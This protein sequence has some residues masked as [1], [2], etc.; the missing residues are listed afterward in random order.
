MIDIGGPYPETASGKKYILSIIDVFSRYSK[1]IPLRV[2]DTETIIKALMKDWISVFGFPETIVSDN[3]SNLNGKLFQDFCK[4]FDII[5]ATSSP[6]H[7]EGNSIV[8]RLFRTVKD[9]IFCVHH[10]TGYNWEEA[11]PYVEI[12][13]RTTKTRD[14]KYSPHEIIFGRTLRVPG[15]TNDSIIAQSS[16]QYLDKLRERLESIATKEK[17]EENP[18]PTRKFKVGENV[19]VRKSTKPD[20][21]EGRFF[22][23]AKIIEFVYPKSYVVQYK[24]RVYR[25]HESFLKR[26]D[27]KVNQDTERVTVI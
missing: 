10:S 24:H 5:K 7:P 9:R 23:P 15:L 6:Y 17:P 3:A 26:F 21:Y 27:C 25:R 18:E 12:G 19:M 16:K 8:E 22:G 14:S 2:T 13:L 20:I 11:I 4:D 1:L